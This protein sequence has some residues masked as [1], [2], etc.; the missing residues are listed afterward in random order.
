MLY[1]ITPSDI[2]TLTSVVFLVLG[3][4]AVASLIPAIRAARTEPMQVLRDE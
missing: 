4:A 3:V 2:T 1:G